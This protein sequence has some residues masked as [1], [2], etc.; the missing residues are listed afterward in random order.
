MSRSCAAASLEWQ[1]QVK[2][3]SHRKHLAHWC[4]PRW[5]LPQL[6]YQHA[7]SFSHPHQWQTTLC[8]QSLHHAHLMRGLGVSANTFNSSQCENTDNSPVTTWHTKCWEY[9]WCLLAWGLHDTCVPC[10]LIVNSWRS[11]LWVRS[12]RWKYATHI[13]SGRWLV[14]CWITRGWCAV[15]LHS[16]HPGLDHRLEKTVV[17]IGHDWQ[18]CVDH[19]LEKTVVSI[20]TTTDLRK[21]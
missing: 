19:R 11:S 7:E 8:D 18:G 1:P 17:P 12:S 21:Q 13:G 6:E 14:C 2:D 9:F 16:T 10:V 20:G 5:P 15:E 3:G 4:R